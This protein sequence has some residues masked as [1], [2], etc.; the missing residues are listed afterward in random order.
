M[1]WFA[2]LIILLAATPALAADPRTEA[3]VVAADDA[4]LKAE[5]SGDADYLDRL[6]LPSY[7]SIGMDGKV[8]DK[9][10]LVAHARARTAEAKAKF[11]E[12]AAAWKAAHPTRPDVTIN[13]D[14][15]ILKWVLVKPGAGD[16]VSSCDIFVYRDGRWQAI[17]SQHSTAS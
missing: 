3:A 4:W 12:Q 10:K 7:V 13:G 5:L 17:Y 14:T 2:L 15:A 9:A 16:P 8:S 1:R 11:A 6:L